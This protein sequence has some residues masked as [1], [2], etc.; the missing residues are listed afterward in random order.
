[1]VHREFFEGNRSGSEGPPLP[2]ERWDELVDGG[3]RLGPE[4][5]PVQIVVFVDFECPF[6]RTF[7]LALDDLMAEKPNDVSVTFYHFPLT[8]LHPHAVG[9]ALAAECAGQNGLFRQMMGELYA[10]SEDFGKRSWATF[11]QSAGVPDTVA[12]NRCLNE[13][14]A[15]VRLE[16]HIDVGFEW[17]V[18]GVPTVMMNGWLLRGSHP[19]NNIKRYAREILN[20]E[21]P[22]P[23]GQ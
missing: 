15:Q 7:H 8:D 9:A 16:S 5:A 4:E 14:S 22:F 10:A 11:A 13:D 23:G 17:H 3:E 1:M 20:G 21:N 6:C 19:R 18:G 2:V 12:F